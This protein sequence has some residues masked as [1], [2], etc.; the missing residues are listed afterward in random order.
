MPIKFPCPKCNSNLKIADTYK[1]QPLRCPAP[2]C[3]AN[4]TPEIVTL[5]KELSE[6]EAVIV[7]CENKIRDGRHSVA[8]VKQQALR[9]AAPGVVMAKVN[10]GDKE[11]F[12]EYERKIRHISELDTID[13]NRLHEL[14]NQ[15][16]ND[17]RT[18]QLG[19]RAADCFIKLSDI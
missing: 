17:S 5:N 18:I 19:H 9:I 6:I 13:I 7:E 12:E 2:N 4:I 15:H 16:P 10:T 3:G 8:I 11:W 14:R 1:G